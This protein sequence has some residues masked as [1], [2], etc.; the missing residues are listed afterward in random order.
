MSVCPQCH[1]IS[2]HKVQRMN[3]THVI[4]NHL[5]RKKHCGSPKLYFPQWN[6]AIAQLDR[7][8]DRNPC[9]FEF[10]TRWGVSQAKMHVYPKSELKDTVYVSWAKSAHLICPPADRPIVAVICT[11]RQRDLATNYQT[12]MV[13]WCVLKEL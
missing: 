10:E 5:E 13:L 12:I 3:T 1:M 2:N 9:D 6:A 4:L 11:R 8:L 7:A